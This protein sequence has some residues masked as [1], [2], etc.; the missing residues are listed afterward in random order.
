VKLQQLR[1]LVAIA[2]AGLNVTAAAQLLHTSQPSISKQLRLLEDELGLKLFVRKSRAL[3]RTTP[4]GD[5]VIA[6]SRVIL[7]EVANIRGLAAEM[8]RDEEGAL[9]IATTHTQARYVLPD[10]LTRFRQKYPGIRVHL[11]QGTSDQIAEII[12]RERIDFVVAT[13]VNVLFDKLIRIPVF[14]WRRG[15]VVPKGH[16]L[17]TTARPSFAQLAQYPIITYAFSFSG[18]SSLLEQFAN[19]GVIPNIALTAWDSDVLKEYIRSGF[20]VGILADISIKE[21]EDSDL[22]LLDASHLFPPHTTWVGFHRGSL[23]R[24]YMYEFIHLLAPHLT[25]RQVQLAERAESQETLDKSMADVSIPFR[26]L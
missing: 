24:S 4:A 14:R 2:D 15:I 7:R 21:K 11:H 6:R 12:E 22:K 10:V 25:K 16:P 9:S 5:K 23:L 26:R 8:R 13:G 18:T 20:G 1:Y 19:A 3:V 17:A